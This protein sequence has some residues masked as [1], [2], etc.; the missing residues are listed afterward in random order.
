MDGGGH[1]DLQAVDGEGP[2]LVHADDLG[3]AGLGQNLGKLV[4]GHHLGTGGLGQRHGFPHMVGVA[5]GDQDEVHRPHLGHRRG[6]QRVR[7]PGV[8]DHRHP[9]AGQ[10]KR[11]VA[12]K[13]DAD[14]AADG[15]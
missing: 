14:A 2:P 9:L 4:D 12:V 1:G 5:V 11:G 7:Q 15:S 8:D 3:G 13:G 6:Q 10:F